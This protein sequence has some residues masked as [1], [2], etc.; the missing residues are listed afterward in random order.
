MINGFNAT[1]TQPYIEISAENLH[2]SSPSQGSF[3]EK[4]EIHP[5][6][7]INSERFA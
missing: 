7:L 1:K 5:Q 6:L 4:S 2:S 3:L